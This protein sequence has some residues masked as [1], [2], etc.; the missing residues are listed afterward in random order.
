MK[1][2]S[3]VII[4]L[5]NNLIASSW[6]DCFG[7]SNRNP[8][9]IALLRDIV[10]ISY[11]AVIRSIGVD[12][13]GGASLLGRVIAQVCASLL[14]RRFRVV[15]YHDGL[16]FD[17]RCI[18]SI[19]RLDHRDVCN[20]IVFK[21]AIGRCFVYVFINVLVASIC[22]VGIVRRLRFR[23]RRIALNGASIVAGGYYW[24]RCRVF[25]LDSA[26]TSFRRYFWFRRRRFVIDGA[27]I[28]YGSFGL[29]RIF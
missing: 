4:C 16:I 12:S 14:R 8:A 2:Q 26:S 10:R 29:Y 3:V 17:V 23:C 6:F 24:F 18:A 9:S 7:A 25:V 13:I 22:C 28:G 1:A 19:I 27:S 15:V 11:I 21:L 5:S 20:R